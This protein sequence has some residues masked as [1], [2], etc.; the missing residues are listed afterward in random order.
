MSTPMNQEGVC[1]LFMG[2]RLTADGRRRCAEFLAGERRRV[3]ARDVAVVL[4]PTMQPVRPWPHAT[5]LAAACG[6]A[7]QLLFD[8]V[9]AG[10]LRLAGHGWLGER[11][12]ARP[13]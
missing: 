12:W 11:V 9:R 3:T 2:F 4:S 10:R 1:D 6:A 7:E 8:E 13:P 5:R